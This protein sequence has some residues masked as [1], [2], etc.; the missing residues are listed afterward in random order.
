MKKI[1]ISS[2][3]ILVLSLI[4]FS[5]FAQTRSNQQLTPD[6]HIRCLTVESEEDLRQL[7]PNKETEAQFE[8]FMATKIAQINADRASGRSIA[9]VY[10]IPVVIHIIHNG[11]CIGTG[12]NITDAQAISQITVMNQDYRRLAGTPGGA[13]TTN[14]AADV[15]I[16][17]VI[18]KVD[19]NG[20]PTTGIDRQN[21]TPYSNDVADGDGG[22]DW[23]TKTDVQTM[24]TNTQWDPTK[25]LNMWTIRPGGNALSSGGLN[26]LLGYA[27]FPDSSG[28]G[29]LSASGGLASTDGVVA[30]FD[31][32][33][34]N[35]SNDGSFILNS[36]YDLGRTMTHEVGHWLGLRHIWGDT[37]SCVVNAT[38]S[39]KDYCP[40]TPAATKANYTCDLAANT[41]TAAPGNDQVQNYMDYT[42]DACMDTFTTNQKTRMQTVMASCPRR[43]SLNTSSAGTATIAGV[44]FEKD[45]G[46]CLIVNEGTNCGFTD[47]SYSVAILK[48]P[49]EAV[50][51]S[52]NIGAATAT[53]NI[54][55]QIMTPTL[56]FASGS[57]TNQN[58]I[59]RY[60]NDGVQES[61]ETLDIS[62]IVTG[63][64]QAITNYTS[65][66]I[67]INDNDIAPNATNLT[68]VLFS[69]NAQTTPVT[70]VADFDGDGK[71][72][73]IVTPS[74][75]S[76]TTWGVTGNVFMSRSWESGTALTPDNLITFSNPIT[77]P[78]A[79]VTILSFKIG[80]SFITTGIVRGEKYSVYLT[81][82]PI[83]TAANANATTALLTETNIAKM[84]S[85]NSQRTINL[86]AYAGQ[87]VYLSF[88][89]WDSIDIE[90]LIVD[91]IE[92]ANV[93]TTDVQ[94]A[95]DN[96]TSYQALLNNIGSFYAKDAS[97]GK[98]IAALTSSTAF[99]YGCVNTFVSRDLSTAGA[100]AVNY[101]ANTTNNAKVMAKVITVSP[102]NV[103]TTATGTIKFYFTEAEIAAWETATG[104]SRTALKVIKNGTG[105]I[106]ETTNGIFGAFFTLDTPITNGL[107]GVYYFGSNNTLKNESL[108]VSNGLSLYPNPTKNSLNISV[109]DGFE[110]PTNYIIYNTIGQEIRKNNISNQDDLKI[111]T[112]NLSKGVYLIKIQN[113]AA[114]STL[115]FIKE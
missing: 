106:T 86:S 95:I 30:G 48:S 94:T 63:G 103:S 9:T 80:S 5:N 4:S 92:I 52:F 42:N 65:L 7:Y 113:N 6:G 2:F 21:I 97:T 100:A 22:P 61:T 1:T 41:C 20:N 69:E 35:A 15:E 44:Y 39:N 10:N 11:D 101:Q 96:T 74:E 45:A 17:F 51:A 36:N 27:Q 55:F 53:N 58:L 56:T 40:D 25:Y 62:M 115:R 81:A 99:N 23:E 82:T 79:G 108:E 12:E 91:D 83:K 54:D 66:N 107:G 24:K 85:D 110:L 109:A 64:G 90:R 102:A 112:S 28:L 34:T 68:T 84:S 47:V 3:F 76:L 16:N 71:N 89:H 60:F 105:V 43:T 88:R 78:A 73:G 26:G 87:T 98:L 29:G 104:N 59:I 70:T 111:N 8:Q 38:D 19:P 13:N 33:G 31:A 46:K 67:S 18:A 75:T 32:F 14:L 50:T 114:T 49:T 72:W 93:L 77:I 57:T 37:T